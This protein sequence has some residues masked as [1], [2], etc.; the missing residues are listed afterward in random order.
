MMPTTT[1]TIP[2][3]RLPSGFMWKLIMGDYAENSPANHCLARRLD[4]VKRKWQ[5]VSV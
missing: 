5:Q 1:E 4:D 3:I 2:H